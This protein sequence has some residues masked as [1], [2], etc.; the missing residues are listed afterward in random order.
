MSPGADVRDPFGSHCGE[1]DDTLLAHA[2]TAVTKSLTVVVP[3]VDAPLPVVDS[4]TGCDLGHQL[5]AR[6]LEK[7][8][9][10]MALSGKGLGQ[11]T[12]L[13]SC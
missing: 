13:S 10:A 8:T 11:C 9:V 3:V 7:G 6:A 5:H 1:L 12:P 4:S 2:I